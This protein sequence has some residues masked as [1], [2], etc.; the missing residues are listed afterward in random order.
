MPLDHVRF[1]VD[2]DISLETVIFIPSKGANQLVILSHPYG[3][4]GGNMDNNVVSAIFDS[5]VKLNVVAVLKYN[6]RLALFFLI[7]V[8]RR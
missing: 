5:L 3:S 4:L 2:E 8:Q 7:V 6:S 1:N